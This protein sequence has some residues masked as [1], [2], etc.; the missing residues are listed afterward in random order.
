MRTKTKDNDKK[1][2]VEIEINKYTDGLTV[3][4]GQMQKIDVEAWSRGELVDCAIKLEKAYWF[5]E[6]GLCILGKGDDNARQYT[7]DVYL[8]ADTIMV[9]FT[10][11]EDSFPGFADMEAPSSANIF[12]FPG[13]GAKKES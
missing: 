1:V 3:L 11:K 10:L 2:W 6:G 4:R 9:I 13:R 12:S 8:R 7:G 5:L